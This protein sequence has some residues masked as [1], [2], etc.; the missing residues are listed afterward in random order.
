[1]NAVTRD[2]VINS[3][4]PVLFD[5]FKEFVAP[6]IIEVMEDLV[7]KFSRFFDVDRADRFRDGFA[8]FLCDIIDVDLNRKSVV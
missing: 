6:G 2:R 7:A 4:I 8:P 1:M 3:G 5:E